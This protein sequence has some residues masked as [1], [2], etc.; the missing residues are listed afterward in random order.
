MLRNCASTKPAIFIQISANIKELP[1][2]K[3]GV[4]YN[5]HLH[6]HSHNRLRRGYKS[7]DKKVAHKVCYLLQFTVLRVR[8]VENVFKI[9]TMFLND[10]RK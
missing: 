7:I 2:P 10:S 9:W 1:F 6:K 5:D 8:R 3:F 4:I